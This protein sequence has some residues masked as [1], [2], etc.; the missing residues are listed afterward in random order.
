M[1][2]SLSSYLTHLPDAVLEY[3]EDIV[4]CLCRVGPSGSSLIASASDDGTVV[5]W[6]TGI[7]RRLAVLH[8]HTQAINDL[9]CLS[10][11]QLASASTDKTIRVR[12]FAGAFLC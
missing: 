4:R 10:S 7:G 11:T 6:D 2:C 9:L 5:V 8:E 12:R 3:H 1:D